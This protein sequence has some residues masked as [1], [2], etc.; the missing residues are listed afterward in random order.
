M[1]EILDK[2]TNQENINKSVRSEIIRL[3]FYTVLFNSVINLLLVQEIIPGSVFNKV[4]GVLSIMSLNYLFIFLFL[5]IKIPIELNKIRPS[6]SEF[7]IVVLTLAA[8]LVFQCIGKIFQ[9]FIY[10]NIDIKLIDWQV[11]KAAFTS[12]ILGF[13]VATI[14]IRRIRKKSILLPI[15]LF[16][17]IF[18]FLSVLFESGI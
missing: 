7:K 13:F 11:V 6:L 10:I 8:F 4:G 18:V 15:F 16:I 3:V 2:I 1:K 14:T 9:L 12:S 5:F 17:L